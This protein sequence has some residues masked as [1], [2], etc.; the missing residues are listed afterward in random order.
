MDGSGELHLLVHQVAV[1]VV[2]QQLG[3]HQRTVE[4]GAQLM[5]HV[6]HEVRLVARGGGQLG[7]PLFDLLAGQLDLG[8]LDLDGTVLGR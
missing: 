8:V 5:G 7:G 4:R 2:G 3:Q 1:Q 6:R